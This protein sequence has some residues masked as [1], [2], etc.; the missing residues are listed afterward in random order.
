TPRAG[1]GQPATSGCGKSPAV[2][3]AKDARRGRCVRA[4][5]GGGAPG[6][7]RRGLPPT[8]LGRRFYGFE[9]GAE[10]GDHRIDDG[11]YVVGGGSALGLT[12]EDLLGPDVGGGDTL[13]AQ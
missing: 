4:L 7:G 5:R 8:L 10:E 1:T 9:A 11:G 3:A 2:E 6:S 12:V 13:R